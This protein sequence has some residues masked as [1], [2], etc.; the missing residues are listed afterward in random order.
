M[1]GIGMGESYTGCPGLV[2]KLLTEDSAWGKTGG[3][4]QATVGAR[5]KEHRERMR[6]T[7]R[8]VAALTGIDSATISRLE[9]GIRPATE[10]HIRMITKGLLVSRAWL[11]GE[12]G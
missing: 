1:S 7:V 10:D 11:M 3:M 2:N 6:W 4:G 9:T 12:E 5:L 8:Q